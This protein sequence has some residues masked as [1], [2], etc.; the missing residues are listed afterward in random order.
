MQGLGVVGD[1]LQDLPVEPFCPLQVACLMLGDGIAQH[2]AD[3]IYRHASALRFVAN[4]LCLLDLRA[5]VGRS[6]HLRL[7]AHK[8]TS[9][10]GHVAGA[11]PQPS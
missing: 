2:S 6:V 11:L 1:M 9:G 4:P 8:S 3:S 7:H 10:S 5:I